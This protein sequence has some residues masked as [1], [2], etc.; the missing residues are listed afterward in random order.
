MRWRSGLIFKARF[1]PLGLIILVIIFLG[2]SIAATA[3]KKPS[4]FPSPGRPLLINIKERTVLLYTE[5]NRKYLVETNP[6]WGIVFKGG[7][8]ADKAIVRSYAAPP[9]FYDALIKIGARPGNNLAPD[10]FGETVKGDRFAVTATWPGL[11]RELTMGEIFC[12]A[13]GRG[14]D[15]RF[16]GN[17]ERAIKE[18]TGCLLCLES[19]PISITSNAA[20]PTIGTV[21]RLF[22]PNSRFKGRS[23]NL[24]N[25]D[26]HP[27]IFIFCLAGPDGIRHP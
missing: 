8:L 5:I 7:K 9:D 27:V 15:I 4:S 6:H 17:R 18:N 19:C 14:F 11:N 13:T 12:D 21:K 2:G 23:D 16:G 1:L 20:Y 25:V 26:H 24:P 10:R 22:S 3:D